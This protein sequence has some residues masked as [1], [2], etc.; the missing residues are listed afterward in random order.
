MKLFSFATIVAATGIAQVLAVP[1]LVV[2]S[3]DI[4]P[5]NPRLGHAVAGNP[6]FVAKMRKGPCHAN[7][8]RQKAVEISNLLRGALGL[9]LINSG[10]HASFDNGKIRI[11]PFIGTPN[12][13]ASVHGKDMDGAITVI[14][15]DTPHDGRH[16]HGYHTH[17]RHRHHRGPHHLGKGS[18]IDRIHYSIMNLGRW[19]G[20]AVAFVLGCG[21][22][23]LLRML[24]ILSVVMY[25][26]VKGQHGEE[27]H[28]YS[29]I[30]IIEEI[31]DN[32]KFSPPSY[33]DEKAPIV[34]ETETV[35][36]SPPSCINENYPI[37]VE[38]VKAPSTSEESK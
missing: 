30:T 1:L 36:A 34:V 25:R 12:T 32:P 14:S 26:T 35:P 20:R 24:Y 28:E 27:Q 37:I 33:V 5:V 19:E 22:G 17:G 7:R 13:F 29:Q 2:P 4:A 16:H 31:V 23:V 8:F 10:S 15:I 9:P 18:F 6:E 38:T 3:N 11:L 21:I